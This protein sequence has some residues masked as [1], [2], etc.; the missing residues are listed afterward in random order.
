MAQVQDRSAP[1][2]LSPGDRRLLVG[3][4]AALTAFAG[5]VAYTI[6]TSAQR[7]ALAAGTVLATL[8]VSLLALRWRRD[9]TGYGD[10]LHPDDPRGFKSRRERAFW[11]EPA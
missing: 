4:A 11:D 3:A 7:P 10:A 1:A 5:V 6:A 9:S 2:P 8:L